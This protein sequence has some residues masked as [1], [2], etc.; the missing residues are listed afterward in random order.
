MR[1]AILLSVYFFFTTALLF[2]SES[3]IDTGI[4]DSRAEAKT[5]L[6][7]DL[8]DDGSQYVEVGFSSRELEDDDFSTYMVKM[9][10]LGLSL[11]EEGHAQNLDPLYIYYRI[12]YTGKIDI[13]IEPALLENV[14]HPGNF[15]DYVIMRDGTASFSS[16]GSDGEEMIVYHHDEMSVPIADSVPI[17]IKTES[18]K[19]KPSGL[20]RGVITLKVDAD[21]MV[22]VI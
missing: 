15:I 13:T 14:S 19:D 5:T 11:M 4:V 1:N 18:L 10:E 22:E 7:L 12:R 21:E 6:C 2:P 3:V 16:D 8:S 20:Y 9:E 17:I